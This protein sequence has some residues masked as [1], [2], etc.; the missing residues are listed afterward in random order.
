M[1]CLPLSPLSLLCLKFIFLPVR[2]HPT[3]YFLRLCHCVIHFMRLVPLPR[4]CICGHMSD[5]SLCF[6]PYS[7]SSCLVVTCSIAGLS[8]CLRK[9]TKPIK[10]SALWS[11]HKVQRTLGPW[12][13]VSCRK[14]PHSNRASELL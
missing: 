1:N 9:E 13:A 5:H 3:R 8:L 4:L 6:F 10:I 7:F 14:A 12:S 11:L 2:S